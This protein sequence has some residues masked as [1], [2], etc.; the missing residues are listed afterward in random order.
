M[1]L[2]HNV[3]R[4]VE[5]HRSRVTEVT[6]VQPGPRVTSEINH[7]NHSR[8]KILEYIKIENKNVIEIKVFDVGSISR[9]HVRLSICP[10]PI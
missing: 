6:N 10:F 4:G 2:L 8:Q 7:N 9:V 3:R 1:A 5:L